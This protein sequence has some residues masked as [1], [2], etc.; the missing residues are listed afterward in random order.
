MCHNGP[1]LEMTVH[2]QTMQRT[3]RLLTS[4]MNLFQSLFPCFSLLRKMTLNDIMSFALWVSSL[5]PKNP[6]ENKIARHSSSKQSLFCILKH[7]SAVGIGH[8]IL[9]IQQ[10]CT[11]YTFEPSCFCHHLVKK[12][13]HITVSQY[14]ASGSE[15]RTRS[16]L[17][18]V[19][20]FLLS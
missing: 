11:E 4:L 14:L 8:D 10:K 5:L 12:N 2:C 15:I 18:V 20:R 16:L 17:F 9:Y 3:V 13:M 7:L 6:P 1:Y 19:L